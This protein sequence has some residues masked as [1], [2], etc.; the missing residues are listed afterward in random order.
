MTKEAQF[1]KFI[2]DAFNEHES[3]NRL[4]HNIYR[5]HKLMSEAHIEFKTFTALTQ[6]KFCCT[7]ATI[8]VNTTTQSIRELSV[9][10]K[11]EKKEFKYSIDEGFVEPETKNVTPKKLLN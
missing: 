4:R 5:V 6:F 9:L 10:R 11:K 2:W 3:Y 1:E 7:I 8:A